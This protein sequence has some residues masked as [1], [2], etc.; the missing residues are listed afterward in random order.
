MG[1]PNQ[2]LVDNPV[3]GFMDLISKQA[4]ITLKQKLFYSYSNT[5]TMYNLTLNLFFSPFPLDCVLVGSTFWGLWRHNNG[6]FNYY[7]VYITKLNATHLNFVLQYNNKRTRSYERT[8][9]VLILDKIPNK[10]DISVNS[11]VIARHK[12]RNPEWYRSGTVV[13]FSGTAYASVKFDDDKEAWITFEN[14]RLVRRP[15]FCVND[16]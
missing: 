7:L 8:K 15:H 11:S 12:E 3:Q 4:R 14:L 1:L 10:K 9:E 5:I 6:A 13:G 2:A 16:M